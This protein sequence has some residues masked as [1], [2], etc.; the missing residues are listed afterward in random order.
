MAKRNRRRNN[1]PG[2]G[3][4][5]PSKPRGNTYSQ[6]D[7]LLKLLKL[8]TYTEYLQSPLWRSIRGRVLTRDQ[9]T[10]RLC[11]QPAYQV[12]HNKYDERTM[13]GKNID[14]LFAI[15]RTCHEDIEFSD[16]GRKLRMSKVRRRAKEKA[17]GTNPVHE[18]KDITKLSQRQEAQ[19]LT[20]LKR[21]NSIPNVGGMG[22]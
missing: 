5:K 20:R 17:G 3:K 10:C 12:H 2:K 1:R 18:N 15:C 9:N 8:G 13:L 22:S 4:A 11:G 6:R 16:D 7:H 21:V 14:Q 19:H